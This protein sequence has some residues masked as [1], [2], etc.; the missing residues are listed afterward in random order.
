MP[1][2]MPWFRLY[3]EF[4]FDPKLQAVTETLQRRYI[5]LLCL[6]CNGDIPGL[7]D[8]Q[9]ACA[10]RISNDDLAKS[11]KKL[12]EIGVIAENFDIPKWLER[13]HRCDFSAE[14]V[15]KFRRN[16]NVTLQKRYSNANVTAPDTD[17]DTDTEKKSKRVRTPFSPPSLDE[18]KAFIHEKGYNVNPEKWLAH[19]EANGWMVGRN[20]MKNWKAAVRTWHHGD[21][22]QQQ[23]RPSSL[24]VGRNPEPEPPPSPR[25]ALLRMIEH[26]RRE[27]DTFDRLLGDPAQVKKYPGKIDEWRCRREKASVELQN[28]EGKLAAMG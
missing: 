23:R 15:A 20:R 8:E 22:G 28:M 9:V 26:T 17:T 16:K 12:L 4:A 21:F 6:R 1:K 14:R 13:Q 5:M 24:D 7:T 27:R 3:A 11:K 10:L 19:Y 25:D 2:G 18:L